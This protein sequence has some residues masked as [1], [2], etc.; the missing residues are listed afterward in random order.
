MSFANV[1]ALLNKA[2]ADFAESSGAPADMSG[3]QVSGKPPF[4]WDTADQLRKA[5]GKGV[6]LI[7]PEVVGKNPKMGQKANLVVDLKTGLNGRPRMPMGGPYL[8][9]AEIQQIIDW[10]DAGCPD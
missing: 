2:L 9:D 6:Q 3:H 10:I 8:T 4:G 1:K 5:W 7:Q